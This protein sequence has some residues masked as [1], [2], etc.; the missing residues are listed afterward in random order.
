MTV[1][2]IAYGGWQNNLRISNGDVEL[3]VT[4]DVGPRIL[5]YKL[6]GGENV[7]KEYPDQLGKSGEDSWMIR[8][9]HRLW[10]SPELPD[11]TYVPDNSPVEFEKLPSGAVVVT[12]PPDRF[13]F[14]KSIA[15]EL[16]P[17][18][19]EVKLTH[20][21]ANVGDAPI[22]VAA[23]A[24]TVMKPGGIE[25]LPLP[26][27]APHPG[28]AT[29]GSAEDFGPSTELIL[30][31]Y[32]VLNDPRWTFGAKYITLKH[33]DSGPTKLGLSRTCGWAG[34]LNGGTLFVKRFHYEPSAT[35]PDRGASFETFSNAEMVEMESLGPLDTLKPGE[36]IAHDET[37]TL[38]GGA[39]A[40]EGEGGIDTMM[41]KVGDLP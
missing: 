17:E 19:S 1:E 41:Q 2:K 9:G 25:I 35:Y 22:E 31:S 6:V 8:G 15:I 37:W 40:G 23:W 4:L 33:M 29:G 11:R 16:A 12:Q 14:R 27:Y 21:I 39:E 7:F 28:D 34:Y 30:W 5:S 20:Q 26:P 18:G 13:G 36:S 24:L 38:L 10:T 3:I 32:T